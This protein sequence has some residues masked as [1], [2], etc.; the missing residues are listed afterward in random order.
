[1]K[2]SHRYILTFL[3]GAIIFSS[4]EDKIDRRDMYT[5]TGQMATDYINATPNLSM[6]AKLLTISKNST[7]KNSSKVSS[8][9]GTRGHYT[10]FAPTN[11]G[12]G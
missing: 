3:L 5:F 9:L 1:M 11:E 10:V 2:F 4:C 8:L 6:F 7:K 12:G